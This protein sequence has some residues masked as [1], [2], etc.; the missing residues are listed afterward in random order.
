MRV[1]S[2]PS[3]GRDEMG[4]AN[5]AACWPPTPSPIGSAP[6][7]S[8]GPTRWICLNRRHGLI[9]T[10]A[11]G[12]LQGAWAD[13]A[14]LLRSLSGGCLTAARASAMAAAGLSSASK[15]ALRRRKIQD[16]GQHRG[17]EVP[18]ATRDCAEVLAK[19]LHLSVR[20]TACWLTL[21]H[22]GADPAVF[23]RRRCGSLHLTA[24]CD[25]DR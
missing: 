9:S 6:K 25:P 23:N 17:P 10:D 11:D 18:P 19:G 15:S 24:G 22:V 21:G 3:A 7:R 2:K 4:F 13:L 1:D 20:C 14:P 5:E 12:R 8:A 16:R